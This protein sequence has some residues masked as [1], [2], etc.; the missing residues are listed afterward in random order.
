MNKDNVS[1]DKE[2]LVDVKV[3]TTLTEE[4]I[5]KLRKQTPAANTKP[6]HGRQNVLTDRR[7][8]LSPKKVEP[9]RRKNQHDRRDKDN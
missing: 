8:S 5:R 7:D 6:A 1:K 3:D 9:D 2:Y 4:E